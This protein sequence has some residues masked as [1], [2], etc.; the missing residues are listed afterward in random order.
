MAY[1]L[2]FHVDNAEVECVTCAT[3][4]DFTRYV[5]V[6]RKLP[7]HV[8]LLMQE[9]LSPQSLLFID[10]LRDAPPN[11]SNDSIS[12]NKLSCLMSTFRFLNVFI[13]AQIN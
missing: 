5:I 1:C 12:D 4:I 11:M 3:S 7:L 10:V 13:N 8:S 6:T 9:L 2:C